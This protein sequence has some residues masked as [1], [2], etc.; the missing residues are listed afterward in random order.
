ED[1]VAEAAE[2]AAPVAES[3]EEAAVVE[4]AP[5]ASEEA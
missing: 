3:V 5:A 1:A 2:E 4:E